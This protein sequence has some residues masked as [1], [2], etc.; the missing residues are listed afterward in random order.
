MPEGPPPGVAAAPLGPTPNEEPST[1]SALPPAAPPAVPSPVP[2]PAD[3]AA[4]SQLPDPGG[5]VPADEYPAWIAPE[6]VTR[7][8]AEKAAQ[9]ANYKALHAA[10]GPGGQVNWA[11]VHDDFQYSGTNTANVGGW[12]GGTASILIFILMA[13]FCGLFSLIFVW[14]TAWRTQTKV[15]VSIVYVGMFVVVVAF[16]GY[17]FTTHGLLP[18]APQV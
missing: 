7:L 3:S 12:R 9:V 1:S 6:E 14:L 8:N 2:A 16:L 18:T 13:W 4:A 17:Y 15:I 10:T 5:P 11:A